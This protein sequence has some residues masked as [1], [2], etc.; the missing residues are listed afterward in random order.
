MNQAN[1]ILVL[2]DEEGF[3]N[4]L[5]EY[6]TDEGFFIFQAGTPSEAIEILEKNAIDIALF[7]IRL[8]EMDGVKLLQTIRKKHP[9]LDVIMMTGF[10]EMGDVVTALRYGALD[11]LMKPF[12]LNDLKEAINRIQKF[13]RVKKNLDEYDRIHQEIING[14]IA[15]V[16]ESAAIKNIHRMV[17]K[18][19]EASDT[20]VL[21]SGES[22]TGK[23][24]LA[25][26]IH[27]NSPRRNERFVPINCSTIPEDLFESEFFGHY[28]G[29]FTDARSDQKGLFEVADKGTLFLDEIG[30]LKYNMQAKLL[31]VIEDKTISRIGEYTEKKVDVRI[32]AATN[33]DLELMIENKQ[34][35]KDLYHRLNLMRINIPPLRERKEDI[36][37]LF[38]YFIA[39]LTK[40]MNK[41]IRKVEQSI[42]AKLME[43]DF[44]GNVRELKNIIERAVILCDSEILREKNFSVM[45]AL[46]HKQK[47]SGF[48][49]TDT[50]NLNHIEADSIQK[51]LHLSKN[52]KSKAAQ[53][54]NISRQAL[55]R[56]LKKM[57]YPRK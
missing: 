39:E 20:T 24:L 1:N 44:P 40:K 55:D 28:K 6:L 49:I 46:S 57:N 31:R 12:N 37:I 16:G 17:T 8:P 13:K 48:D 19:A 10:G 3:R 42:V 41:T 30:D 32:I 33:Q 26:A 18:I 14:E 34:F 47:Q 5:S 53:L 45:D 35:R 54:L 2:D 56:K 23:E 52:N 11:F 29:S 4:E 50:F 38:D 25:R 22:G 21:I 27:Y 9:D 51:A 15:L 36:P 7:D 43:Y